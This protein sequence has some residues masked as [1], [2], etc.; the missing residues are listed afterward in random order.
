MYIAATVADGV[1]DGNAAVD[2]TSDG[3]D[4]EVDAGIRR[5]S[6]KLCGHMRTPYIGIV[7]DLSVEVDRNCALGVGAF[8]IKN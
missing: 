4:T 7:P 6:H 5:S 1:I 8:Y 3:V 2:L